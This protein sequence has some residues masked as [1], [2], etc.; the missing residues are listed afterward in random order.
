M[1]FDPKCKAALQPDDEGDVVLRAGR[2]YKPGEP[3]EVW[4]GPQPNARLLLNYGF[5]ELDN[6][7][8]RVTI[9]SELDSSDSLYRFKRSTLAASGKPSMSEFD[10]R[11]E[12][13]LPEGLLPFLR[14]C[15]AQSED[16]ARSVELRADQEVDK[17]LEGAVSGTNERMSLAALVKVVDER[18]RRY[19]HSLAETE[20]EIKTPGSPRAY[21]SAKLKA[22]EMRLLNELRKACLIDN[23]VAELA[24][25]SIS[26]VLLS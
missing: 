18:L 12:R 13:P 26:G 9:R 8:D 22:S 23:R 2:D 7:H 11:P 19:P 4:S 21:E 5:A 20:E 25:G 16:E 1:A 14:V 3:L 6:P 15:V 10:V 17:P 24:M